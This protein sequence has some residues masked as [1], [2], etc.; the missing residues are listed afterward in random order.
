LLLLS[1]CAEPLPPQDIADRFWRAIVAGQ[2]SKIRRYVLA[3][4][5]AQLEGDVAILA[6]VDYQL[7]RIVIDGGAAS[8][9]TRV[10]LGADTTVEVNVE[11]RLL[12]ENGK[13]RVDYGAT[14][15]DISANSKLAEVMGKIGAL[16]DTLREGFEQSV[17]EMTQSLPAIEREL[18]RIEAQIKQQIPELRKKLESLSKHIEESLSPPGQLPQPAPT[19]DAIAL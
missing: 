10:T 9:A 4:N 18:G 6:V 3:E 17:D 7:G 1:S 5:Q 13:W 2:P 12:L 11:T 15:R 19:E 14:A 8:I 16:G